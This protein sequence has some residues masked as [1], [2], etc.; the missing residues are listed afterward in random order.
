MNDELKL[1]STVRKKHK[2]SRW[3]GL[4]RFDLI[5]WSVIAAF[6]VATALTVLLGDRIGAR[7]L[8]AGPID[9]AR[10]TSQIYFQF[11][12]DMDHANVEQQLL[13]DPPLEG[14]FRWNGR[15]M[16]FQPA[17]AMLPDTEY[18]VSLPRGATSD[19]GR[20]TLSEYRFN[21]RVM[22]PRVAYLTPISPPSN[23]WI[24]DPLNPQGARQVTF[25]PTGIYDF[26]ISPDGTSI[27][28]SEIDPL[29]DSLEIKILNIDTG[30]LVQVTNCTAE[31]SR[32]SAPTWRPDGGMI[33]YERINLNNDLSTAGSGPT[34][35]WLLDMTTTPPSTRPL[36]TDNQRLG[37]SP[38]WSGDGSRLASFDTSSGGILVYSFIDNSVV[39]VPNRSGS[40]GTLS[41]DGQQLVFPEMLL[42]G[43]MTRSTLKI[44]D[45]LTSNFTDL[46]NPN[47]PIDDVAPNWNPDGQR[48][49]IGRQYL[50]DRY[51]RGTQI[52]L[53]DTQDGSS[54]PL[55]TDDRYT[56][57][58]F[59]WDPTG[60]QLVMQR[61]AELDENGDLTQF[62]TPEVW[63]YNLTTDTLTLIAPD[64]NR[65][66]WVP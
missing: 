18:T 34:R 57:G 33:A 27:A 7:V 40:V 64:A 28:F 52:Y 47:E 1:T 19:T 10:S 9:S 58:Y 60:Q 54:T 36:F 25:S 43:N 5:V 59:S 53:Y 31:D 6:L 22:S 62:A 15:I 24:A 38:V 13:I 46:T 65:P 66:R 42:D 35:I 8:A 12:E 14:N 23:I 44:A 48:L 37:Y 29:S 61:F 16:I 39:L 20:Q 56:N 11:S 63:T 4:T 51:T 17:T 49:A 2:S 21:F 45:L 50:D 41:P 26:S 32:C 55:V 30:G 3:F